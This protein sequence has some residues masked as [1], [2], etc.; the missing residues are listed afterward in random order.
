MRL[1]ALVCIFAILLLSSSAFAIQSVTIEVTTPW[2]NTHVPAST[3]V[4]GVIGSGS[5]NS[6]R[7][8]YMTTRGSSKTAVLADG[9]GDKMT[10]ATYNGAGKMTMNAGAKNRF[11]VGI[12]PVT[13]KT[14]ENRMRFIEK[15]E[16]RFM[17]SPSFGYSLDSDEPIKLSIEYSNID[18]TESYTFRSGE[19]NFVI[20]SQGYD[21]TVGK[22]QVA[23][24]E[25]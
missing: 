11:Y 7:H 16:F 10:R 18:I 13:W 5:W 9:Y 6:L 14:V 12:T 17:E 3:A 2:T 21:S 22:V 20:R 23:V 4:D 1:T 19:Y 24:R 15:D 8:N 25:R